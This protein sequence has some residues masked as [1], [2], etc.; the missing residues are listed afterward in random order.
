MKSLNHHLK[1][2]RKHVIKASQRKSFIHHRWFVEYHLLLVEKIAKELCQLY[3]K[4]NKDIVLTLVW[5]HDYG[6]IK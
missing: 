2:F 3:P 6:K 5:L 1:A 4:A